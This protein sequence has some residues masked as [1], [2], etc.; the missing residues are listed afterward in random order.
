[1]SRLGFDPHAVAAAT[2][3]HRDRYVDLLRAV[4]I[5]LV[6]LGH[7]LAV[8]VTVRDGRLSGVNAGVAAL[9][10]L[11]WARPLTWL[12]QVMPVFFLVGGYANAASWSS[13]Q[14][15]GDDAASWVRSRAFRLLR[16][17]AV[18][19]VLLAAA[20]GLGRAVGLDPETVRNTAWVTAIALWFVPVY[21]AIVALAPLLISWQRRW[22]SGRIMALLVAWVGIADL[23]RIVFGESSLA[24]STYLVAWLAVHQLGVAW[25]DGTLT[26]S[27][28]TARLLCGGGLLTLLL[29]TGPGP[30]EVSMLGTVGPGLPN[31]APPTL[32][33]LA[34]AMAQTGLI[35][36]LRG[37][38]DR[39]L[40]KPRLWAAVVAVNSVVLTVYLW[41]MVP[42][43][44]VTPALVLTG[45]L[46]QYPLGSAAWL[47]LRLPWLL[48]LTIVLIV[49]IAVFA[50]VEQHRLH[51]EETTQ[52]D[53][54]S[55]A[56]G[57]LA[58]G[59][60]ACL[61]GLTGLVTTRFAGLVP[62]G[63]PVLELTAFVTGLLLISPRRSASVVRH[64]E[65]YEEQR[66]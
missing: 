27:P 59:V 25:R 10:A 30:Y 11:P 41:H 45:V 42:L 9:Q 26:R 14:R 40:A 48:A 24:W 37:P 50:R 38:V 49:L 36:M 51:G 47:L 57:R 63:V 29:L 23:S 17:T 18:F 5:V 35:L 15:R 7:W 56:K 32:A 65:P 52:P 46:P 4:A 28:W 34:L 62:V 20:M 8:A 16:P 21:L 19:V 13:H 6:V 66:A 3:K 64:Q 55:G 1:M 53:M 43:A 58:V 60:L 61:A 2:P 31:I 33:L 12:F 22:G 54:A 39:W 44:V